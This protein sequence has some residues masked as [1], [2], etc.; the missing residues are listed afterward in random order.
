[1]E[2]RYHRNP[3]RSDAHMSQEDS[4][5]GG[6]EVNGSSDYLGGGDKEGKRNHR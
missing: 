6:R 5:G 2:G 1:M 3:E 4:K